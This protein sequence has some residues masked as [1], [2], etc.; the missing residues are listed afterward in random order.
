MV[1]CSVK[2]CKHRSN[3]RESRAE[4]VRLC[5]FPKNQ[6]LCLKWIEACGQHVDT[7]KKG[8]LIFSIVFLLQVYFVRESNLMRKVLSF[9]VQA[10]QLC[11]LFILRKSGF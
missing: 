11:A 5:S 4:K 9:S 6:D 3:R 8:S 1:K 10:K 2:G 7:S